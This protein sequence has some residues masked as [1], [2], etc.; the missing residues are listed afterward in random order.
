MIKSSGFSVP[1]TLLVLVLLAILAI[2]ITPAYVNY[3]QQYRLT[4]ASESLYDDINLARSQAV[5]Q[6]SN[7]V[8]SIQTGSGWCYGLTVSANCDCNSGSNCELG[9]I[10][11]AEFPNTSLAVSAG[12][13][14]QGS[15]VSKTLSFDS[16]RGIPASAYVPGTVTISSTVTGETITVSVN[17]LG[18]PKIC[19][20]TV[21]GYASC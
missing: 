20:S 19:S 5:K 8:L 10:T 12:F 2:V 16:T 7:V 15:P 18:T 9:H 11:S 13:Q 6:A 14:T 21:G 4:S 17:T 1:E 3:I